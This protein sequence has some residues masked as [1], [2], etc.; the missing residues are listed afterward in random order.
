VLTF[1]V[2]ARLAG[3]LLTA[4]FVAGVLEAVAVFLRVLGVLRAATFFF[5]IGFVAG[6]AAGAVWGLVAFASLASG[7]DEPTSFGACLMPASCV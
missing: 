1:L 6:V 7:C 4:A 2:E 3:V 5:V